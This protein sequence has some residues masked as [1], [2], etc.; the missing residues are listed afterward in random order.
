MG[1]LIEFVGWLA[2]RGGGGYCEEER[3]VIDEVAE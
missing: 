3:G 1:C 2:G